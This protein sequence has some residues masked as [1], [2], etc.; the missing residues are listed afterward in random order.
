MSPD[1]DTPTLKFRNHKGGEYRAAGPDGYQYRVLRHKGP[2]MGA[3]D[4]WTAQEREHAAHGWLTIGSGMASRELAE[5]L[6]AGRDPQARSKHAALKQLA[7]AVDLRQRAQHRMEQAD[8]LLQ[9][10]LRAAFEAGHT[11]GPL[12]EVTGLTRN[13]LYQIRDGRRT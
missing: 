6:C 3:G 9:T 10:A 8:E 7:N 5:K 11:A 13:R 2:A 12:V 1:T 4:T